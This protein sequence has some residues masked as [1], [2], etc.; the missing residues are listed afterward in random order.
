MKVP[1]IAFCVCVHHCV[2]HHDGRVYPGHIDQ[3]IFQEL[4][5]AETVYRV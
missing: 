3:L 2:A 1:L 5:A 4:C